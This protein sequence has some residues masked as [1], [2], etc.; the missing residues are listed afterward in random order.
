MVKKRVIN[1]DMTK[2][3]T[4]I[5]FN[6]EKYFFKVDTLIVYLPCKKIGA[7]LLVYKLYL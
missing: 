1:D 4:P 6:L 7:P 5:E 3:F 2:T